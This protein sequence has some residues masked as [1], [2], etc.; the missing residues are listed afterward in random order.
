MTGLSPS[1]LAGGT[2][3]AAATSS[4]P[5]LSSSAAAEGTGLAMEIHNTRAEPINAASKRDDEENGGLK[6]DA[7]EQVVTPWEV[8]GGA[9]GKIDYNKLVAQFGCQ[10]I[11]EAL[12]ARIERVTGMPAHPFLKRGIFFAHR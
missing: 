7:G 11:D 2:K 6:G 3:A 8:S 1:A 5:L 12:V 9:D 10:K 4:P